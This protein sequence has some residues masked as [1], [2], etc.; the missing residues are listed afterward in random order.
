MKKDKIIYNKLRID[1]DLHYK[2]QC[3]G[4][5][6]ERLAYMHDLKFLNINKLKSITLLKKSRYGALIVLKKPIESKL[7]PLTILYLEMLLGDDYMKSLNACMNYYKFKMVYHNR[8]FNIKRYSDGT[9]KEAKEIDIT[10]D[11]IDY[12]KCKTRNKNYN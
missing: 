8:L 1:L 3:I 9:I 6:R 12:V 4:F 11:V 10:K 7:N 5:L 2:R